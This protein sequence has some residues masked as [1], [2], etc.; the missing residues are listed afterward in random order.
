V[1]KNEGHYVLTDTETATI[2]EF[3]ENWANAFELGSPD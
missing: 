2:A 3:L 1:C